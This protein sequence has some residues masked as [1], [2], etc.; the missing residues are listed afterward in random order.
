MA[1][2]TT[3]RQEYQKVKVTL[4][5]IASSKPA[6]SSLRN[7]KTTWRHIDQKGALLLNNRSL[8]ELKSSK[9]LTWHRKKTCQTLVCYSLWLIVLFYVHCF[10]LPSWA[11]DG[12]GVLWERDNPVLTKLHLL[13][14]WVCGILVLGTRFNWV[15]GDLMGSGHRY[16]L[17]G[18]G[19]LWEGKRV[20]EDL[21]GL[22]SL[23]RA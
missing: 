7:N 3:W 17:L 23:W 9:E 11:R 1:V 22:G 14:G 6:E 15:G 20:K 10:L 4:D 2:H 12:S 5:N 8:K 16:D 18:D 19:D 13:S 21:Q